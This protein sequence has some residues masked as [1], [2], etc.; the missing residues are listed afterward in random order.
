M[1]EDLFLVG[2]KVI[3]LLLCGILDIVLLM[4]YNMLYLFYKQSTSGHR[5]ETNLKYICMG[6]RCVKQRL[7]F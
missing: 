4:Y 7:F 5:N 3:S 1:C 6:C 2:G